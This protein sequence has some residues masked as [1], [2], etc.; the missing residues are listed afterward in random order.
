MQVAFEPKSISPLFHIYYNF[1]LGNRGRSST[2]RTEQEKRRRWQE[3]ACGIFPTKARSGEPTP[4]PFSL[5]EAE[6]EGGG[7]TQGYFSVEVCRLGLQ[8]PTLFKAK[9]VHFTTLFMTL[10]IFF[11]YTELNFVF[12][13]FL[14]NIM[15]LI[16]LQKNCSHHRCRPLIAKLHTLLKGLRSKWTLYSRR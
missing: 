10:I 1:T 4:F 6:G 7:N 8:T 14:T 13:I 3:K 5:Y 11:W 16:F 15:E 12:I 9:I 2:K